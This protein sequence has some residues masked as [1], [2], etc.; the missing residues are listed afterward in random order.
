MPRNLWSVR[1]VVKHN[2][3]PAE[4]AARR[5]GRCIPQ[6]PLPTFQHYH[7][8]ALWQRRPCPK[9]QSRKRGF[10]ATHWHHQST[11]ISG[12]CADEGQ[13]SFAGIT[14][15]T[16]RLVN[17]RSPEDLRQSTLKTQAGPILTS[18]KQVVADG[19]ALNSR[20]DVS[21]QL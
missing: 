7:N 15:P 4:S 14:W 10:F 16:L 13:G 17:D 12:L 1:Q 6:I 19:V 18:C 21:V 20:Q 3:S 9:C 5:H 2:R 11:D 8:P